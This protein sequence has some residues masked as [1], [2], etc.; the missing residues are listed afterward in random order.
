MNGAAVCAEQAQ[1]GKPR[2][3]PGG[4]KEMRRAPGPEG[5]G[6]FPAQQREKVNWHIR[7]K[8]F[9]D[10]LDFHLTKSNESCILDLVK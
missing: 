9:F 4:I 6:G 10:F 2:P 7:K 5:F 3:A 1:D 8:K